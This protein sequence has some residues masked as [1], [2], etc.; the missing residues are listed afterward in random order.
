MKLRVTRWSHSTP[1][2]SLRIFVQ[3]Q[4]PFGKSGPFFLSLAANSFFREFFE[5]IPLIYTRDSAGVN[6]W[7][8]PSECVWSGPSFLRSKTPIGNNHHL[9]DPEA[10]SFL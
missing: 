9:T 5:T 1:I 7:R 8:R 4:S 3:A 2:C 6:R 10:I